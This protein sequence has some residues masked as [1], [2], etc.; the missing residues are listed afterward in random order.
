MARYRMYPTA[1]QDA[2]LRE[3]C[4]QARYVWNLAWNLHQFGQLETYGKAVRKVDRYGQGY[5]HQKHRPV[6]PLPGY[7]EQAR[8]LTEARM[9]YD[10]LAAGSV[11]VQQ[12]ALRDFDQAMR[13]FYAA[14]HG[15]PGP[16][17]RHHSEGFRIVNV[18][19]QDVR[20][21]NRRWGQVRVPKVGWVRIRWSRQ[22]PESKSYRVTVDRAGR[23]HVAFAVIPVPIPAPG[24]GEAVGVDRG[25]A[26]TAALSTGE[27]LHCPGLTKREHGRLRKAERRMARAQKGSLQ[28]QTERARIAR[29]RATEAD[30][31]KDWCE[32]TST[33]LARRFDVIR[34]E[35][36][37]IKAMTRSARGTLANPGRNVGQKAGL[38]RAI[39]AQG[40]GLL[41]RRTR[42]KAPGRVEK[43]R[44]AYTSLRC[45]ACGWIDKNSR[46]SQAGFLCASCGFSGNADENAAINIAAGHAGGT[47]L[48]VR[49]PLT[50]AV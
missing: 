15:R 37:N 9:E 7:V 48:S 4:A 13:N 41:V 44:A 12:Q 23:W 8:M 33:A 45:S 36:L 35:D 25:V 17:R 38:N 28:R 46:D 3:H 49:E 24:T 20:R 30:R 1:A 29:L 50:S 34:F 5:I 2:V 21:L 11:I 42:D 19:S 22:A 10:W 47:P 26:I 39:L 18:K 31:R 32:K 16:R 14:T 43:V 27:K 40:W 6:R